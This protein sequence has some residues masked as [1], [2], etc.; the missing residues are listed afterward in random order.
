MSSGGALRADSD[1]LFGA[2][3][4]LLHALLGLEAARLELP[5]GR[6]VLE[7]RST[8]PDGVP[9]ACGGDEDGSDASEENGCEGCPT[10]P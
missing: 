7:L 9:M 1:G 4:A 10:I 6:E 3:G 5:V 8:A 2:L